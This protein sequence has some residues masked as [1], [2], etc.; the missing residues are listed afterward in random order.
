MLPFYQHIPFFSIVALMITG[1]ITSIIH[2]GR[3]ALAVHLAVVSA[4]LAANMVLWLNVVPANERFLYQLGIVA[5]PYGNELVCGPLEV[6]MAV[7]FLIV[8][9]C[10]VAGGVRELRED[11]NEDKQNLYFVMCNLIMAS[12]LAMIYTNDAFTAYVFIEINTISA[13]ALVMAKDTG[14]TLVATIRYL[15][16]SLLGS[17]LFL[18]GLTFLYQMTGHLLM[19]DIH[20]QIQ[21]LMETGEYQLPLLVTAGMMTLGLSLKS[22]LFPFHSWLPDAHGSATT[23][24]SAILSGL[25]LKGYIMLLVKMMFS[26]FGLETF[27][28]LHITDVILMLGALAMLAGSIQAIRE[29]HIKRM[30]AYSSVAQIG[31]IYLGFGLGSVASAAAAIYQI[32]VHAC[33]KPLLFLTAGQLAECSN[34]RKQMYYLR[35]AGHRAKLAGVGFTM[36]GLS[37]IGLPLLG[38]FA[39]KFYLADAALLGSWKLWVAIAAL[40]VSSVLNALYYLPAIVQIWTPAGE[41]EESFRCMTKKH[42]HWG[43]VAAAVILMAGCVLLGVCCSGVGELLLAGLDLM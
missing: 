2:S 21:V 31:Y 23:S 24:S 11:I 27:N 18:M 38:G 8:M 36:G 6:T 12:L 42:Y 1:I 16:M 40:A 19:I 41:E 15:I 29:T 3:K 39:V 5:H 22:A 25:V 17:G 20:E 10:C 4:V 9:L 33:T 34:H 37:M 26:I 13:C 7:V 28:A 35:G 32:M 30:I 43:F 14:P